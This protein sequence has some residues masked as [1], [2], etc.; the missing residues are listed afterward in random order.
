MPNKQMYKTIEAIEIAKAESVYSEEVA[1]IVAAHA[2]V[3]YKAYLKEGFTP[4]QAIELC[5]HL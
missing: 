2:M 4:E 3:H 5:K 1:E